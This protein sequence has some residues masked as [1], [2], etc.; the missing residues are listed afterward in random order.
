MSRWRKVKQKKYTD[1]VNKTSFK[2]NN[3]SHVR[4]ITRIKAFIIDMFMIY[5]PI[6]YI[7]TYLI[8][9]GKDSFL[10]NQLAILLCTLAFGFILSVL[11]ALK[12]QSIGYKAYEIYLI[13]IKT[14]RQPTFLKA[15]FRFLC[16]LFSW[17]CIVGIFVVFFR[18]DGKNLHDI[19]SKTK[20]IDKDIYQHMLSSKNESCK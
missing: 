20:P 18:K 12:G 19:L 5:M 9:D 8:L 10:N 13:D 2:I 17:V 11:F 14:N 3:D 16:F 7:T 1:T 4:I 6:L 15:M